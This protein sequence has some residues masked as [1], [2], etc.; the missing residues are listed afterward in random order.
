MFLRCLVHLSLFLS[1]RLTNDPQLSRLSGRLT[2]NARWLLTCLLCLHSEE[3]SPTSWIPKQ[4][5]TAIAY[6]L[7][8]VLTIGWRLFLS[9]PGASQAISIPSTPGTSW[10]RSNPKRPPLL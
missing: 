9:L 5:D 1:V 4:A 7:R 2:P 8:P 10:E 6:G 3:S